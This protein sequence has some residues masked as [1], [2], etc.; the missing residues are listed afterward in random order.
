MGAE[1]DDETYDGLDQNEIETL[2]FT[3]NAT[4]YCDYIVTAEVALDCD[5]DPSNNL[6]QDSV[7]IH[8]VLYEI[9]EYEKIEFEDNTCIE[10]DDWH[11]TEECSICPDDQFWWCG[12]DAI[13]LYNPDSNDVLMIN[14]TFDLSGASYATLTFEEYYAIEDEFDYGYVEI[15]ND[16][17]EHWFIIRFLDEAATG[18]AEDIEWETTVLNLIPGSTILVSEY[19]GGGFGMPTTFFTDEMQLRFRFYSDAITEWKGWYI[20]DVVFTVDGTTTLFSDDM[21]D[22]DSSLENWTHAGACPG[23]NHWHN[24][25][26]FGDGTDAPWWWNGEPKYWETLGLEQVFVWPDGPTWPDPIDADDFVTYTD[27]GG[28]GTWD[29]TNGDTWWVFDSGSK[30]DQEDDWLNITVTL[31][32]S[33]YIELTVAPF[34]WDGQSWA[35]GGTHDV[36]VA[37]ATTYENFDQVGG[38][39]WS[40]EG[41]EWYY[42]GNFGPTWPGSVIWYGCAPWYFD[43][44]PM[45][46]ET[47]NITL[48]M[49]TTMANWYSGHTSC[50][51][52]EIWAFQPGFNSIP[53]Q[54]Y[55]PNVDE[56]VIYTFDL[57]QAT[58][59]IL[60]FDQN[61]TFA[62]EN[63]LGYVEISTDE[64]E[65]W[66]AILVNKGTS[67]GWLPVMLDISQ[68]AGGDVPV[69]IRWRFVSNESG[70]DYGWLFDNVWIDGKVDYTDPM[71]TATLSPAA[72][73]GNND[74]YTS[75]V[76][77]TLTATDNMKVDSIKYRIDGGSW[78]TYTAPFSIGIEG[79]HTIEYYA[80][81]SVGN[82]GAIGSVSF[83][84]DKTAPTGSINVPQAGYIYFFGRELM[85]R[86]LFRDKAL[87]I[88][89][90]AAEASASDSTSG[91]YV[92][93]FNEDGTTFAEDT[94][95]PYAA[96]LPFSLFGSHELTMTVVDAAGNSYTTAS[97]PYF[98]VF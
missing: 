66:Q 61:Y 63:D 33:P 10:D 91:V 65:T 96:P 26:A 59:A 94:T 25:S 76:T 55:Y 47:I 97:V 93:K 29:L 69:K 71:I 73:N 58:E 24:E 22:A 81:D 77:V 19:T 78:L 57:T 34:I 74:W 51:P 95:S 48:H 86:I 60:Y 70:A 90:L 85:P 37:N 1:E 14:H 64:G 2:E 62:D 80:I 27:N 42:G 54:E 31:P 9:G 89:G 45:A 12:D 8:E 35:L 17:G 11:L 39:P 3:W 88:G 38:H 30:A 15:T 79:E 13:G 49:T 75:D 82:E 56:K 87:I 84:I 7:R 36:G 50:A 52:F 6:E 72:P 41:Y 32:D 5:I 83:K 21:E 46:G 44:S 98:K 28:D 67:G 92:V 40:L 20:D 68:Y 4:D 16:S 23:G 43:I 53:Y 18:F